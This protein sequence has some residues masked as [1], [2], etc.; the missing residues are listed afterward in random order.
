LTNSTIS[1][2]TSGI[3][4]DGMHIFL[5][6]GTVTNSTI[7]DNKVTGL[8]PGTITAGNF[9]LFG[10]RG[11]TNA[12][13]FEIFT[14]GA[15]D[16]TATANG[17]LPKNLGAILNTTLASNGARTRTHAL[18]VGSP[19]IDAVANV[20]TCPPPAKDQRGVLRPQDGNNDGGIACD[21]GAFE[22]R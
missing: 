21:T 17:S 16:I 15:T 22:R 18:V 12:Q 5:T 8:E 20:D 6:D 19:A 4:G 3:S 7:S 11:L 14:P 2:N 13:A 10:H 9:N 1:G